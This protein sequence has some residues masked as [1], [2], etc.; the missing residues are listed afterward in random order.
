MIDL[1]YHENALRANGLDELTQQESAHRWINDRHE[2]YL[3]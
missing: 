3:W 1:K 2:Q